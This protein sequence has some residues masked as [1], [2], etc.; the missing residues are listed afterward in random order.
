MAVP[1]WQQWASEGYHSQC[2][3]P[4][5][6]LATQTPES[7]FTKGRTTEIVRTT[8][9]R[10]IYDGAGYSRNLSYVRRS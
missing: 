3:T 1:I 9:V 6:P 8:V 2:L 4:F 5:L 10:Q 7:L